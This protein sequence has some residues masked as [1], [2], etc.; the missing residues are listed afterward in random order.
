MGTGKTTSKVPR[1]VTMPTG[2]AAFGPYVTTPEQFHSRLR[3]PALWLQECQ[4]LLRAGRVLLKQ[5]AQDASTTPGVIRASVHQPCAMLGAM[6]VENALKAVIAQGLY[7]GAAPHP[8][9]QGIPRPLK[10]HKLEKLAAT[11]GVAPAT[12]DERMLL[13]SGEDIITHVGRYPTAMTAN[14]TKTFWSIEPA[15]II[16]A[17][18]GLC[19]SAVGMV[20]IIKKPDGEAFGLD[21]FRMSIEP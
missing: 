7:V 10:Q 2:I 8:T 11:A 5:V 14:S 4:S 17:A 9:G 19:L 1:V 21:D 15:G 6:A 16:A 12:D 13:T 3:N 20:T 18:E